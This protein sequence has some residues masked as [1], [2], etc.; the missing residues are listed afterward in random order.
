LQDT[1][2]QFR[3]WAEI[4]G[5]N[6]YLQAFVVAVAFILLGKLAELLIS[7]VVFK[8]VSRSSSEFDDKVIALLH[9]PVFIS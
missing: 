6:I 2:E 1:I 9:R 5:P 3:S 8:V 7:R 4:L